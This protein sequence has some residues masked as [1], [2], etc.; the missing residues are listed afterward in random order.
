MD[1]LFYN[2]IANIFNLVLIFEVILILIV[3]YK[4]SGIDTV[5][6]KYFEKYAI[7]EVSK[8]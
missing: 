8:N 3:P 7:F 5:F 4:F 2:N 6:Q 1:A